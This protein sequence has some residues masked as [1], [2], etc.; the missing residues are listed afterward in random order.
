MIH[1]LPSDA[2]IALIKE[3]ERGPNGGFAARPYRDPAGLATVGWGHQVRPG[4]SFL[5]PLSD[6]AADE[7]LRSDLDRIAPNITAM[8]RNQPK[9]TQSMFDALVCLGFNIGLGALFGSS[10]F[11]QL[12]R[13]HW[14]AAADQFLRWDKARNPKTGRYARLAGLTRRRA[15]ERELFLRDGIPGEFAT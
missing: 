6:Y 15:A 5:A 14:S 8:L 11:V 4:E 9:I 12:K 7:L 2:A 10:L 3:F 1:L 13:G